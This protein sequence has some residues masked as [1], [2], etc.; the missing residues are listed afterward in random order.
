METELILA[1]SKS[2]RRAFRL[3]RFLSA[4]RKGY[5]RTPVSISEAGVTRG[6]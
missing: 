4:A 1:A 3:K 5:I 6:D 2:K